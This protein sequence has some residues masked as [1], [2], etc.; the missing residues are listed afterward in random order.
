MTPE[1]LSGGISEAKE[2]LY[3]VRLFKLFRVA[4]IKTHLV[5]SR[6]RV[7][8]NSASA[9]LLAAF[10]SGDEEMSTH[11]T[12]VVYNRAPPGECEGK[13][14]KRSSFSGSCKELQKRV[15]ENW[16]IYGFK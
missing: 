11:T 4:G 16:G 15:L 14:P 1:R 3:G 10:L 12:E 9:H 5:V 6:R 2:I 13:L 8:F 7:V